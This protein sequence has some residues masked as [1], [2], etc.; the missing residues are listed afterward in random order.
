MTHDTQHGNHG[1][2]HQH[3]HIDGISCDVTNCMYNENNNYCTAPHIK[4]G[5]NFAA[6]K[7]DT[8]CATFENKQ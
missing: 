2:G 7:A 6:S 8:V 3:E 1:T 5:P 4:V